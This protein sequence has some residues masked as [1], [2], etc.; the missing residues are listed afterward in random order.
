MGL[1]LELLYVVR[2]DISKI[3]FDDFTHCDNHKIIW[4]SLIILLQIVFSIE[5]GFWHR[6]LENYFIIYIITLQIQ[7][8]EKKSISTIQI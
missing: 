3:R 7:I 5:Q 6:F 8:I 1:I 2:L 4:V